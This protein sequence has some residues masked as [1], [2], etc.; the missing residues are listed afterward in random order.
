MEL[1]YRVLQTMKPLFAS[2]MLISSVPAFD[3]IEKVFVSA[4]VD[5]ARSGMIQGP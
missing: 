2:G 3:E 1:E 5:G 4:T